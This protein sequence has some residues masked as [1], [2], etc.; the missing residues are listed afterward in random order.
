MTVDAMLANSQSAS[1]ATWSLA[2]DLLANHT[3]EQQ[4]TMSCTAL[5]LGEAFS[6][7]TAMEAAGFEAAWWVRCLHCEV[8]LLAV[9]LMT[10]QSTAAC[11]TASTGAC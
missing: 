11:R 6:G 10:A 8:T 2:E 3:V 9:E 5:E 7:H 4:V 1:T